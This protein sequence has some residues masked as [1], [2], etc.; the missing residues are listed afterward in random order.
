[1]DAE[2]FEVSSKS[3][4][5]TRVSKIDGA[6][7]G[8][9][10]TDS[11]QNLGQL[12][13]QLAGLR[14]AQRR[15]LLTSLAEQESSNRISA[16]PASVRGF[17]LRSNA[18]DKVEGGSFRSVKGRPAFVQANDKCHALTVNRAAF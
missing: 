17:S 7:K 11:D 6:Q 13:E 4:G 18:P 3:S 8:A 16:S 12:L 10:S 9:F 1:L 2:G 5:K 14:P 15:A